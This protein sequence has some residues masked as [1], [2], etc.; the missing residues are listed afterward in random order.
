MYLGPF[1]TEESII[2]DG[3]KTAGRGL[4]DLLLLGKKEPRHWVCTGLAHNRP[5]RPSW[6]SELLGRWMFAPTNRWLSRP[7][8]IGA[9]SSM[10]LLE[11]NSPV[12]LHTIVH[13]RICSYIRSNPLLCSADR[14]HQSVCIPVA[15]VRIISIILPHHPP[16]IRPP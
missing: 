7:S 6:L 3:N 15:R 14:A 8:Q 12:M 2:K 13:M 4:H 9:S 1:F 10:Q 16:H 5:G 11:V